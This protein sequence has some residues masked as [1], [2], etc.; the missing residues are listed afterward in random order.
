M[1]PT[2]DTEMISMAL[3]GLNVILHHGIKLLKTE[4]ENPYLNYFSSLG[5][6]EKLVELQKHKSDEVYDNALTILETFY[7]TNDPM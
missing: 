4:G 2:E 1:N 5:G 7:D 3:R 6:D